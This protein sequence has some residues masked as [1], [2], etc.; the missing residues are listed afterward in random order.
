MERGVG[1]E[2]S[3]VCGTVRVR[4]RPAQV[5]RFHLPICRTKSLLR[6]RLVHFIQRQTLVKQNVIVRTLPINRR[7]RGLSKPGTLHKG[8]SWAKKTFSSYVSECQIPF[9]LFFFQMMVS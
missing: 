3:G 6:K 9:L 8:V 4:A 7:Q 5:G 1:G 2:G